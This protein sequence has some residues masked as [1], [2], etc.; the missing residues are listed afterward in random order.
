MTVNK[1]QLEQ[2]LKPINP[3]RIGKDGKG[4]SH[5]E[6][7]DVR[8]HL[9]RIFGFTNW[10]AELT[11]LQ[12]VFETESQRDGKSRW[13]VC[14]RATVKL[15]VYGDGVFCSPAIYTEAAAGD[16]QNNPS[17]ADAHDMA[18]KTAESQAFKRAAVNLG[19]QFGLSLYKD[20]S[21][22]AVVRDTLIK[23]EDDSEQPVEESAPTGSEESESA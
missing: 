5:L 19:D 13:S 1:Q 15:T 6:A 4:F 8:A 3:T 11:D 10:S 23:P 2:L 21:T 22:G 20:G 16:S 9:T 12:L 7:W 17:R 18:I 14:Y